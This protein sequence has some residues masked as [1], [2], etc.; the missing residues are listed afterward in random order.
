MTYGKDDD[1]RR[2]NASLQK[3]EQ[4]MLRVGAARQQYIQACQNGGASDHLLREL[5]TAVLNYYYELR[6]YRENKQIKTDWKNATVTT[7]DGDEV[8]GLGELEKW[9]DRK[10]A[11]NNTAPGRGTTTSQKAVPDRLP[12]SDLLRLSATLD[13]FAHKLGF[14]PDTKRPVATADDAVV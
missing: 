9:V 10:R 2:S 3:I 13:D 14:T 1:Q 12:A 6:P 5:H 11:S 4:A 8:T 7:R